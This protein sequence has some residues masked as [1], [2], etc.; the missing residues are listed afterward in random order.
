MTQSAYN[1]NHRYHSVSYPYIHIIHWN[2]CGLNSIHKYTQITSLLAHAHNNTQLS[3]SIY[4]ITESHLTSAPSSQTALSHLK[5]HIHTHHII[6]IESN[7]S[8]HA[9]GLLFIIPKYIN[10]H[11]NLAY[12]Y[13]SS[14]SSSMLAC[15]DCIYNNNVYMR[16][17]LIYMSPYSTHID[18]KCIHNICVQAN[19][20]AYTQD[21][22]MIICGDFNKH[23]D[24]YL[25]EQ[26][27]YN[28]NSIYV[29]DT[30]T[31]IGRNILD[32]TYVNTLAATAVHTYHIDTH[33][34]P[35]ISDHYPTHLIYIPPNYTHSTHTHTYAAQ[36]QAHTY[37]QYI[38]NKIKLIGKRMRRYVQN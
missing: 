5:T 25:D 31:H 9:S 20:N 2:A 1:N 10:Y 32:L 22:G 35:L 33:N 21:I 34:I 38:Y 26:L 19:Q 14:H 15:I 18:H 3:H 28:L 36:S 27:L 4:C 37:T 7:C 6:P 24:T 30:P 12:R 8:T 17:I 29:P 23:T 16:I 13:I 11:I